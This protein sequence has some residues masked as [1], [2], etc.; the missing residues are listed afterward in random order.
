MAGMRAVS[1]GES[2]LNF[3]GGPVGDLGSEREPYTM[4]VLT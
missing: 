2:W 1:V 4:L 3:C